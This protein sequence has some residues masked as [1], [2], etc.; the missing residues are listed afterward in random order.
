MSDEKMVYTA[1]DAGILMAMGPHQEEPDPPP[2]QEDHER[3]YLQNEQLPVG[4]EGRTWCQDEIDEGDTA[5]IRLDLH[6]KLLAER[7]ETLRL[8]A[9]ALRLGISYLREPTEPQAIIRMRAREKQLE[10]QLAEQDE[11]IAKMREAL[12]DCESWA[13]QLASSGYNSEGAVTQWLE[14]ITSA[15][16]DPTPTEDEEPNRSG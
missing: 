11:T 13:G 5:Y 2:E 12:E 8:Q 15:L 9:S 6:E 10:K 3:I 7:D 16:T 4:D 14:D 1:K